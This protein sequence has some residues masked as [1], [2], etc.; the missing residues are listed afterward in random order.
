V[1]RL[2]GLPEEIVE[3][4]KSVLANLEKQMLNSRGM[5]RFL[6][7]ARKASAQMDLFG[8]GQDYIVEELLALPDNMGAE[9]ARK[10]LCELKKRARESLS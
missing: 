6:P 2:A 1:A 3:R 5:P 8:G 10:T 9:E 7:S 4:A